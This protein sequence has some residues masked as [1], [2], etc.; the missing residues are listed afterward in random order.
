MWLSSTFLKATATLTW[1]DILSV[2]WMESMTCHFGIGDWTRVA[3]QPISWH[4]TILAQERNPLLCSDWANKFFWGQCVQKRKEQLIAGKTVL[5]GG[6]QKK[7]SG[8]VSQMI[9]NWGLRS[10]EGGSPCCSDHSIFTDL[11]AL[12]CVQTAVQAI[13][14]SSIVCILDPH[15]PSQWSHPGFGLVWVSLWLCNQPGSV[16][17][18]MK[19]LGIVTTSNKTSKFS[20]TKAE[21][22]Q[23][24]QTA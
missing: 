22:K 5:F 10:P 17:V 7:K 11:L 24:L 18:V 2:F 14:R 15:K 12:D 23:Y 19:Y 13:P 3:P 1:P 16:S 9:K 6:N 4:G 8:R 21:R 20:H